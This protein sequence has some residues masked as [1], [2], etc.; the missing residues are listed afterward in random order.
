MTEAKW[1]TWLPVFEYID[2]LSKENNYYNLP[3][4]SLAESVK[5]EINDGYDYSR[6]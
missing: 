6:S 4:N 3:Y 1:R 2:Q 5:E